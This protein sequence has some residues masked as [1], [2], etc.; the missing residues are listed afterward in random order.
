MVVQRSKSTRARAVPW[1]ITIL[2]RKKKY[3]IWRNAPPNLKFWAKS[4]T[5]KRWILGVSSPK[6][7]WICPSF[8][9]L[10]SCHYCPRCWKNQGRKKELGAKVGTKIGASELVGSSPD[11]VWVF[12]LLFE[13]LLLHWG[14]YSDGYTN[15]GG[16][17]R[18]P[19]VWYFILF[20]FG[21]TCVRTCIF[22]L[23]LIY[24]A[25][26][27]NPLGT[28]IFGPIF[29]P[30]PSLESKNGTKSDR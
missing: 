20:Y 23:T 15:R 3:P 29:G 27:M 17:F 4:T 22:P 26:S 2:L 24:Q 30:R 7:H 16:L 12:V 18:P 21:L 25:D 11:F 10:D 5:N 19:M 9:G 1:W 8:W 13:A 6:S 28:Y 14:I